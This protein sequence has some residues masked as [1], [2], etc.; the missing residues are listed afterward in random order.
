MGW[1]QHVRGTQARARRVPNLLPPRLRWNGGCGSSRSSSMGLTDHHCHVPSITPHWSQESPSTR[2][3]LPVPRPNGRCGVEARVIVILLPSLHYSPSMLL[4]IAATIARQLVLAVI[5]LNILVTME[6][7]GVGGG[8]P[9]S[10]GGR[11]ER[12]EEDN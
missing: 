11:G 4:P 5:E 6:N 9:A 10:Q 3:A 7:R 1:C 2:C 8:G 12:K